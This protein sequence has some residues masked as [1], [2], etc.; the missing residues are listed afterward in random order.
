[1]YNFIPH[2]KTYFSDPPTILRLNTLNNNTVTEYESVTIKCVVDSHPASD[3][4][5]N[6]TRTNTILNT[7][8]TVLQSSYSIPEAK[9]QHTGT[10][11]CQATNVIEERSMVETKCIDLYVRCKF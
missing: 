1:M 10:Y 7:S 9:C 11:Q 5:W 8:T 6:F 3:I 2:S 4:T